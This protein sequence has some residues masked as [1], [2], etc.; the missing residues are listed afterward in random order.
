MMHMSILEDGVDEKIDLQMQIAE[1]RK[2][3]DQL[4]RECDR[5]KNEY[6]VQQ[7][8][9]AWY[10]RRINAWA[11]HL[12]E[13]YKAVSSKTL[14][15]EPDEIID[16]FVNYH[17]QYLDKSAELEQMKSMSLWRLIKYIVRKS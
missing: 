11:H 7:Q 9:V 4:N 2:E 10:T 5:W 12:R 17:K 14:P 1:L 6:E 15:T 13:N 8:L 3:K 16:K